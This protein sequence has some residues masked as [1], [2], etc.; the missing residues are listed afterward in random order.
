MLHK[1][2]TDWPQQSEIT[3]VVTPERFLYTFPNLLF[4]LQ[5]FSEVLYLVRQ[6]SRDV[7]NGTWCVH[8]L[9][10]SPVL[11]S[12]CKI[13]VKK[14]FKHH[15]TTTHKWYKLIANV[16]YRLW[17]IGAVFSWNYEIIMSNQGIVP[18]H[19]VTKRRGRTWRSL[20]HTN[21]LAPN[22]RYSS[23]TTG[24]RSV[25]FGEG[26]HFMTYAS[27]KPFYEI[28]CLTGWK[29]LKCVFVE[30]LISLRSDEISTWHLARRWPYK[31]LQPI[32][33]VLSYPL[34]CVLKGVAHFC[35]VY[36]MGRV[37]YWFGF[38]LERLRVP[39]AKNNL[40]FFFFFILYLRQ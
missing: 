31:Y 38:R 24:P 6:D 40:W 23:Q 37:I 36:L 12:F 34:E 16:L 13:E 17:Q 1:S 11:Q 10:F 9:L 30:P 8:L 35:G 3:Y 39:T 4:F 33:R 26:I 22:E 25:K 27:K 28:R 14:K 15:W 19:A 18:T 21:N 5:C 29:G 32:C 20:L 2:C 7:L